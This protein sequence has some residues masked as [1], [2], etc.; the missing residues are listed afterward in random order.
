MRRRGVYRDGK[1]HVRA[2]M[3]ATCIFHPGNRMDLQPG[4]VEGMVRQALRQDSQIPCHDTLD[5]PQA[6]CRGF[7]DR[8]KLDVFP[9]RLALALDCVEYE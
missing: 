4:R 6:V 9:L 8:H 7:W 3:C 2:R 1:V 5:G